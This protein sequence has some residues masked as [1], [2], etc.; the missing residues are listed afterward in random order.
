[1]T[2]SYPEIL[3]VANPLW[4]TTLLFENLPEQSVLQAEGVESFLDRA[5][6]V[7]EDTGGSASNVAVHLSQSGF[8][9]AQVGR[10]GTDEA[11]REARAR[12]AEYGIADALVEESGRAL[13]TSAI[14]RLEGKDEG[15]FCA[16]VPKRAVTPVQVE[17]VPAS[18]VLGAG[19]VH[20][21]RVSAVGVE[22]ARTRH[23]AGAGVSLD[24]HICPNRPAAQ[25]RLDALLP[26]VDMLQISQMAMESLCRRWQLEESPEAL[27]QKLA[28]PGRWVSV[29]LGAQGAYCSDGSSP[30][31][32]LPPVLESGFVDAT[33]AGDAFA[34]TMIQCRW[35]GM[36]LEESASR[37]CD[38]AAQA[39]QGLGALSGFELPSGRA[40]PGVK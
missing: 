6:A 38:V 32:V 9:V 1:M 40:L 22:L 25:E 37:A 36:S 18:W 39:C 34:A 3:V 28:L 15:Y 19:W 12:M 16:W 26:F 29:T 5:I 2:A 27:I 23:D 31:M 35:A 30:T 24:L 7:R 4:E 33:G 14:V 21:D 10:V 13:K 11:S 17:D 20:L 8:D